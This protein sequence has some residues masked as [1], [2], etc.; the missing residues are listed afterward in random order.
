MNQIKILRVIII[1][2]VAVALIAFLLT[3]VEYT[4]DNIRTFTGGWLEIAYMWPNGD[5]LYVDEEGLQKNPR[6]FFRIPERPDQ[7][8]AG[9]G[10]LV[11]KE[12]DDN[13]E[14]QHAETAAPPLMTLDELKAKV[15]FGYVVFP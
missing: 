3:Q 13:D 10:L 5:V 8:L 4:S 12:F 14:I 1:M 6:Y 15:E 2:W 7:S 11:G 9:D